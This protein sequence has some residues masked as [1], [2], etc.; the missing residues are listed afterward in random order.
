CLPTWSSSWVRTQA[1][2][3]RCLLRGSSVACVKVPNSLSSTHAASN[4]SILRISGPTITCLCAPVPT[5]RCSLQ[6]RM[7]SPPK[8]LSTKPSSTSVANFLPS[9]N[10]ATSCR[11]PKIL[12]SEEHTSELQSRE[13]LVCRLLLEKKNND[14]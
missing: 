4:W 2:H 9:N 8:A 12:R 10:G 1:R 7:S 13:N 5:P 14:Q 11:N 6:W 3:T